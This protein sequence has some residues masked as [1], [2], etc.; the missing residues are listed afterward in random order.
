MSDQETTVIDSAMPIEAVV[1]LEVYSASTASVDIDNPQL[2]DYH[3]CISVQ[4]LEVKD[5]F[6]SWKYFHLLT[7]S[8]C[9]KW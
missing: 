5:G 1:D 8:P 4:L 7:S 6:V 2:L 9:K 3:L